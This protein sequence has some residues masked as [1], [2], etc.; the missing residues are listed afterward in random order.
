M[1]ETKELAVEQPIATLPSK[2]YAAMAVSVAD[3]LAAAFELEP[4]KPPS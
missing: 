4:P 3:G 1:P 2:G